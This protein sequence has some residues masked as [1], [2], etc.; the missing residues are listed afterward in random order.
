LVLVLPQFLLTATAVSPDAF[1]ILICAAFFYGAAA[2]IAGG[3]G[4]RGKEGRHIPVGLARAGQAVLV[5]F[6]PVIALLTDR[7]AFVLAPLALLTALLI[8]RRENARLAVPGVLFGAIAVILS[9]YF[10]SLRYP[11]E[12]ERIIQSAT[13]VFK[14]SE[15]IF[16]ALF[17]FSRF[18]WDFWAFIADEFLLK[19]GWLVFGAPVWVY[20]IWRFLLAAAAFGLVVRLVKWVKARMNSGPAVVRFGPRWLILAFASIGIQAIG[21]WVFYG[22]NGQFGQG[23]YFFPV[24]A[25]VAFLLVWGLFEFGEFLKKGVGQKI[26]TGTVLAE[27]LL[28]TF[29]IWTRMAPVF[30]LTLRGP[31]PGV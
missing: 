27:V 10:V 29:A 14:G 18:F 8:V 28:L 23:R 9:A 17:S 1:V 31:H 2:L 24:I 22:A 7:S 13:Y 4:V 3:S 30:H 11:L 19:F 20:W 6:L 25:P 5:A 16:P 26:I 15:K 21:T 12:V